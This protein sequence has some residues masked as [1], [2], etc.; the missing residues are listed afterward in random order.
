[1]IIQI[2]RGEEGRGDGA[3]C[4]PIRMVNWKCEETLFPRTPAFTIIGGK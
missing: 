4:K 2:H 1:M 3:Q